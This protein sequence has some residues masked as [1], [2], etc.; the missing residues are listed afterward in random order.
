MSAT[1]LAD[2][3]D[4]VDLPV[5]EGAARCRTDD[6]PAVTG[7]PDDDTAPDSVDDGTA[8]LQALTTTVA[9][10]VGQAFT[11]FTEAHQRARRDLFGLS[12]S[13][14]GGCRRR[15]AYQVARVEP[16]DPELAT[17]GENRAAN[18]GTMIHTGLLP[19]LAAVL[20]G[21]DEVPVQARFDVDGTTITVPG[22]ADLYV[23]GLRLLL[24]LKTTGEHKLGVVAGNGVYPEHLMQVSGYA[25]GLEEDGLPVDWIGWTYLDRGTGLSYVVI[26]RFTDEHREQVRD[27]VRELV[28][29]SASPDDAPRDGPGPGDRPANVVCNGCAWLRACWGSTAEP[30]VAGVQSTRVEDYGGMEEVLVS[31]LRAREDESRD[32][33]RKEFYRELFAHNTPGT[34]G[35]ARWYR[36]KATEVVDKDA[37]VRIVKE[38]GRR[39]P[40]KL[41]SS[42]VVV[43]WV[44]P[45][46][47]LGAEPS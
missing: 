39:V 38:L 23:P 9:L 15:A 47:T 29:Y 12:M 13:G 8:E 1:A 4:L 34:Y 6:P 33:D 18:L 35:R 26:E 22:S 31:Y 37:C 7:E 42:R 2:T 19:E 30:G 41:G 11:R 46:Q 3:V 17:T 27:R 44:V 40:T 45:D 36:T 5:G 32:G 43:A 20:D 24:D 14:L 28:N 16:S 10:A 21:R 25:I